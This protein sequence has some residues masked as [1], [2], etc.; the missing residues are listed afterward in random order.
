M[1]EE[2]IERS[3][4]SLFFHVGGG[5]GTQKKAGRRTTL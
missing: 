3:Y 5:R 4:F 2:G 1:V